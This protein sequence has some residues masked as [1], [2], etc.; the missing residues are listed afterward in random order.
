MKIKL[1]QHCLKVLVTKLL[2]KK[3][4]QTNKYPL[5]LKRT[6]TVFLSYLQRKYNYRHKLCFKVEN[7]NESKS[8]G[9][10]SS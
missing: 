10:I 5:P 3:R 2:K 8:L 1:V 6:K 4:K 7:K 9:K